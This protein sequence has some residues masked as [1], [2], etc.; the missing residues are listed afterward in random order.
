MLNCATYHHE[1]NRD[2][3]AT[4]VLDS[5]VHLHLDKVK[6]HHTDQRN[7]QLRN[8]RLIQVAKDRSIRLKSDNI[9]MFM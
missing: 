4:T 3:N 1:F 7:H 2:G 8:V 9:N 5:L 6:D